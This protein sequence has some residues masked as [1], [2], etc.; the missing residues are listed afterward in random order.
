MI[1]QKIIRQTIKNTSGAVH[2]FYESQKFKETL[3][4][5]NALKK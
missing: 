3:Q 4:K 5:L 1:A 2:K